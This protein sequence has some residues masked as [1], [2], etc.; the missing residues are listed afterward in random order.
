MPRRKS[1]PLDSDVWVRTGV[2]CEKLQISRDKLQSLREQ[3]ILQ[4][5]LHWVD[6][7]PYSAPRYRYHLQN[8]LERLQ[9]LT[10]EMNQFK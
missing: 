6:I 10:E 2:I 3:K 8:C 1:Q 9:A 4:E 7:N 5:R